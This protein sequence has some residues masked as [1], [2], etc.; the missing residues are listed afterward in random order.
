MPAQEKSI[1]ECLIPPLDHCPFY[2]TS[3]ACMVQPSQQSL[4]NHMADN[5]SHLPE[6]LTDSQ[7]LLHTRLH[8]QAY[9]KTRRPS[10]QQDPNEDLAPYYFLRETSYWIQGAAAQHITLNFRVCMPRYSSRQWETSCDVCVWIHNSVR[11]CTYLFIH[12]HVVL[13]QRPHERVFNSPIPRNMSHYC[14]P[15]CL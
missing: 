1:I 6:I 9:Q 11:C 8:V 10:P 14:K 4:E 12:L 5:T 15:I 13:H 3:G 7:E 2:T